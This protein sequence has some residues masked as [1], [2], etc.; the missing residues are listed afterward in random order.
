M[1]NEQ[2]KLEALAR[3]EE[4]Y[5]HM[6]GVVIG[7]H[8][9]VVLKYSIGEKIISGLAEIGSAIYLANKLEYKATTDPNY[10]IRKDLTYRAKKLVTE[11][12]DDFI[13]VEYMIRLFI[14]DDRSKVNR[15]HIYKLEH[16]FTEKLGGWLYYLNSQ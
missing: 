2:P 5:R 9:L 6:A 15:E 16:A 8:V 3:F 11:A 10:K 14:E 13:R 4:L 7:R 1:R 12:Q